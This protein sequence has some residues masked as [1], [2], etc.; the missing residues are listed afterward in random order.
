MSPFAI[1]LYVVGALLALVSVAL[2]AFAAHGL[3]QAAPVGAQA[4][5]WFRQATNFQMNHALGLIFIT[6]VSERLTP[7]VP[8]TTLR[9]AAVVMAA[10]AILF[11]GGLYS[12]SFAGPGFFAPWGGFAVM[13]GWLLFAA[14]ALLSF[15]RSP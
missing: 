4:V 6:L 1:T 12:L 11:P 13:A 15:R 8:K 5:D 9:L 14:G 10:G 3:A 7:G 2:D